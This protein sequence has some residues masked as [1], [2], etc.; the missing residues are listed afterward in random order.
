MRLPNAEQAVVAR[1]KITRYLL[2]FSNPKGESKARYFVR[3]GFL[4]EEWETFA[5]ALKDM[6][7]RYEVSEI[8]EDLYGTQYVIIGNIRSPDGRN[9]RV[10]CVWQVDQGCDY[11]RFI[12]AY[13]ARE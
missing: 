3:F 11:P 1:E 5:A 4:I 12:S 9:P 8:E 13:R 7:L 10:R 6:T 2:S